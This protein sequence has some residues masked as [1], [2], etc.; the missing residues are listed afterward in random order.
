MA[1]NPMPASLARRTWLA[2]RAGW[3]I[4]LHSN[5]Q[6]LRW[7]AAV[8]QRERRQRWHASIRSDK[9]SKAQRRRHAMQRL[10]VRYQL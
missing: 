9:L 1:R 6:Q 5:V 2:V 10:P 7:Q 8:S 4:C 3:A